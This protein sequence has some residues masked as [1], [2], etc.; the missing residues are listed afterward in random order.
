MSYIQHFKKYCNIYGNYIIIDSSIFINYC[1]NNRRVD[2][3][4]TLNSITKTIILGE[5]IY[6]VTAVEGIIL[7]LFTSNEQ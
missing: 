1:Y 5:F 6:A 7:S 3:K 4:H 2:L